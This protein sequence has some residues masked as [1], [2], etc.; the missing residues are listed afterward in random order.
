MFYIV[1]NG[2]LPV[3]SVQEGSLS[4]LGQLFELKPPSKYNQTKAPLLQT[5]SE[6]TLLE[7]DLD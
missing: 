5:E 1:E 2:S 6:L 3:C 7:Q 4:V